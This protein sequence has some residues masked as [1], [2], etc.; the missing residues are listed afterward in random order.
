M[1]SFFHDEPGRRNINLG[2]ASRFTHSGTSIIDQAKARRVE[3][4]ERKRRTDSA[5]RI[6]AWWRGR[7]AAMRVRQ[8]I[9]ASLSSGSGT[10]AIG[11]LDGLRSIALVGSD[12][13]VLDLW[14]QEMQSAGEEALFTCGTTDQERQSWVVLMRQIAELSLRSAIRRPTTEA[15]AAHLRLIS[16]LLSNTTASK[17]LGHTEGPTFVQSL[18]SYL[19]LRRL[20]SRKLTPLITHLTSALAAPKQSNALASLINIATA[21][22][23]SLPS[24]SPQSPRIL[25]EF[26]SSILSIPHILARI[27]L[28][29]LT[30]L[31]ARIPFFSLHL[32]LPTPSR[33]GPFSPS[34][35]KLSIASKLHLLAHLHA[36]TAPRYTKLSPAAL[37][38]YLRLSVLIMHSIPMGAGDPP[39]AKPKGGKPTEAMDVDEDEDGDENRIFV[40]VLGSTTTSTQ[41]TPKLPVLDAKTL[42][43]LSSLTEPTHITSLLSVLSSSRV[44]H[45]RQGVITYLLTVTTSFPARKDRLLATVLV[46][47]PALVRELYRNYV[48]SSPLGKDSSSESSEGLGVLVDPGNAVHWPAMVFLAELY[49]HAL[50]TMGDDEFFG[51][52]RPGTS[53]F[54]QSTLAG[55]QMLGSSSASPAQQDAGP[56]STATLTSIA[57]TSSSSSSKA[58]QR[59]RNPLTLDELGTFSRQMLGAAFVLYY[60][61]AGAGKDSSWEGVDLRRLVSAAD[62]ETGTSSGGTLNG[63]G[64]AMDVD[65]EGGVKVTGHFTWDMVRERLTGCLVGVHARDSRK[66][67]LPK[68]HWLISS[69]KIDLDSFVEAAIYEEQQLS[70]SSEDDPPPP[71]RKSVV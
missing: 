15:A 3:R 71:D 5:T 66:S 37:D 59:H 16:A 9:K 32:L 30:M 34:L 53:L 18:L 40:T 1:S 68:D 48:R 12:D 31:S 10:V 2:G 46:H 45:L 26:V 23:Q 11:S 28:P 52:A 63:Q 27:P 8:A 58:Q 41:P 21:P 6:Q 22:L 13:E 4:E 51:S 49:A 42:K 17:H 24:S 56:G 62:P 50:R 36:L 64:M 69:T 70:H 57:S 14:A 60:Y 33:A 38:A 7:C 43:R 65:S 61:G 20:Y 25:A 55:G 35:V 44:E 39:L 54:S 47:S 29:A 19:L 67:F